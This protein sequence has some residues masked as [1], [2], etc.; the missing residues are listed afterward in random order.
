MPANASQR[1]GDGIH[2]EHLAQA[3]GKAIGLAWAACAC[4]V[5]CGGQTTR[6]GGCDP[7]S[8]EGVAL[9]EQWIDERMFEDLSRFVAVPTYRSGALSEAEV[10]RNLRVLRDELRRQ[11]VE[12]GLVPFEWAEPAPGMHWVFGFRLG[13]GIRKIS[14]ITHL[15]TVPP[16]EQPGW[17]PF[18][19]KK[20]PRDYL[21]EKAQPF[22]VGRGAID[23]KGPALVTFQV[24]RALARSRDACFDPGDVTVE[25]LFDT[26]E[27][28]D[29]SLPPYLKASA[30][31]RP[32]LGVSYD[33]A[34]CIRAEKGMERP[35][36]TVRRGSPPVGGTWI[37]SL[38]T[39][40]GPVNQIPDKATA[41]I[42]SASPS[43]LVRLSETVEAMYAGHR[44]DDPA[45]RPARLFVHR[46][47]MP[48]RLV[49]ETVVAGAQ[50]GSAP[51]ENRAEGANPLVSL[52]TFLGDLVEDGTIAPSD[53]GQ[54]CRFV[55][56]AFGTRVFGEKHPDLLE[57][58]DDVFAWG[59]GTTYALT[60]FSTAPPGST[61]EIAAKLE[62]DIRYAIGHHSEPWDHVS[63]GL[64]PG[65]ESIF[66]SRVFP[67]L[68]ARYRR[69]F[70]HAS[71]ADIVF[72][73]KTVFPPDIRRTDG[74]T[75]QRVN[76]AYE[77]VM[78][79]PCPAL[80][81]GAATDMKGEVDMISAG[82][83]FSPRVGFPI[84]EHASGEG[85]PVDDLRKGARILYRLLLDEIT[86]A[87]R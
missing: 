38:D 57:R 65:E 9:V 87:P 46:D 1:H 61:D 34:W 50:H 79:A 2:R 21:G 35:V 14:L 66:A 62:V 53:V 74:E 3:Q 7:S 75:F 23:D 48:E 22:Y 67:E 13:T 63:E 86:A 83:A 52:A 82:P 60:R 28:T 8:E 31:H 43:M 73:T 76:A 70:S 56:W 10:D 45:Y 16:G 12:P 24:L 85:A 78:G 41:V 84:N 51:E 26:S 6:G 33:A 55:S 69:A 17:E 18:V 68:L 81:S 25:V 64:L 37:E 44:F 19:L 11:A 5:G 58:S 32:E 49:L 29:S 47:R 72:S 54:M 40:E 59:N 30:D 77:A 27:E 80:A 71:G 42:R 15:D 4:A 20:E 39:P 36:F